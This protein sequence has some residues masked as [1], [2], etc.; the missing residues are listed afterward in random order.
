MI[1]ERR[2]GGWCVLLAGVLA[3]WLTPGL[4]QRADAQTTDTG[5]V[6]ATRAVGGVLIDP[7]GVIRN[8]TQQDLREV[9]STWQRQRHDVPADLTQPTPARAISLKMLDAE[10]RRAAEQGASLPEEIAFLGG[11]TRIEYVLVY[12]DQQDIVIVGPAEP[13][14][15]HEKGYPVGT[16]SGQPIM[17]LDDLVVALRAAFQPQRT[18]I[19]CSIDPTAE[20]IQRLN[21]F[22][23]ARRGNVEPVSFARSLEQVVGPQVVSLTGVP[24]NSH[25]ARVLVAADFRMKQISMGVEPAPV[26]GLPSFVA[27]V[28]QA[29]RVPDN[30]M[31]RWWLAPDYQPL[32]K[33]AEG[34]AW[35]FQKIAVKTLAESD[36]YNA[37]GER[38]KTAE[39]APIY[40]KWAELFT[41]RYE[42]LAKADPVFGQVRN[43]M[44]FATLGALIAQERLLQKANLSLPGLLGEELLRTANLAPAKHVSPAAV[45]AR[46]RGGTMFVTG[47]VQIN[48]W[49]IASQQVVQS[50]LAELRTRVAIPSQS[51]FAN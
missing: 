20:G 13:W 8:A 7:S 48:A 22:V 14:R 15:L 29:G 36:L 46:V 49:E 21:A 39:A 6:L 11:L 17:L 32:A 35:K 41:A 3:L 37:Q 42:E 34:L 16:Q 40:R 38:V 4:G 24:E 12:P 31:P 9:L 5:A 10:V 44:D 28:A 45:F 33:D 26:A 51:W 23:R 2:L 27:L 43:C 1:R 47:G 18:V 30:M 19:S 50:E 25:F